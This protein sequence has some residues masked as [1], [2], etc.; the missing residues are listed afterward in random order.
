MSLHLSDMPVFTNLEGRLSVTSLRTVNKKQKNKAKKNGF[1]VKSPEEVGTYL[2]SPLF[3]PCWLVAFLI[4][5]IPCPLS[6][7]WILYFFR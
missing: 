6:G 5:H 2:F 4:V 1:V 7:D 3:S